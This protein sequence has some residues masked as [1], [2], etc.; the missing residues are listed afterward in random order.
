MRK[1]VFAAVA[2]VLGLTVALV[3][4]EITLRL[5][6]RPF[7]AV[8]GWTGD[9]PAGENNEFGF[10]GHRHDP[11][12]TSRVILLGDSQVE[13]GSSPI[14]QMPEVFLRQVLAEATG[15]AVS[16]TSIGSTGWGQDQQLLAL[17]ADI[18]AIHPAAVALWFTEGNDLW[19]NTFPTHFPADGWPKPTFWLEGTELRGPNSPWL[20]PYRPSGLYLLQ[21]MRRIRHL[22]NYPTDAEWERLL[23][24]PY[25]AVTA[26]PGTPSLQQQLADRSGIG[27]DEV[28]YFSAEN[29]T[30]EKT[31]YSIYL[32]PESP[33]LHYAAALTRALLLRIQRLCEDHGARFVVLTT[34][35]WD[36]SHIPEAP[37]LFEVNGSGYTLSAAAARQVIDG[38]LTG[39]PTLR[40]TG[41][42]PD[43]V[44]SKTDSHWNAEG[45]TYAMTALGRRLLEDLGG[46]SLKRHER[47]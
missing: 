42:S 12:A 17:A 20:E 35:R 11:G 13:A 16:V 45:N 7:P 41:I 38:V 6:H 37:T 22:P 5:T 29:F 15:A 34:E 26:P 43:A 44:V 33:R 1:L 36:I 18:D 27:R 2:A 46:Q 28:P 21:A 19:N 32:V 25:R 4:A 14:E 10:R 9:R 3:A 8:I 39:L 47:P 30:T 24:P 40:V 31:H 23:P